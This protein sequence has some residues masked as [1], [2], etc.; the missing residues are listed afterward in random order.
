MHDNQR[1]TR[2]PVCLLPHISNE[3]MVYIV[4]SEAWGL[5][6]PQLHRNYCIQMLIYVAILKM[7]VCVT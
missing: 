7:C 4:H 1:L 6:T 5:L 2:Q 3:F